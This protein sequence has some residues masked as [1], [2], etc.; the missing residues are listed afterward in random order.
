MKL[1]KKY[2]LLGP[3]MVGALC[4]LATSAN[5][6][7]VMHDQRAGAPYASVVSVPPGYTT[8]YIA[9]MASAVTNPSAPEGSPERI[10]DT[11]AQTTATLNIMKQVLAKHGLTFADV[12]QAR[13][14]LAGDPAK[15]GKMDYAGMNRA[16]KMEFGSATQPNAPARVTVQISALAEPGAL[17]EI[18]MTAAKKL[19]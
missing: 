3:A 16:W 1:L 7:E 15:G 5:A 8:Y 19:P 6:A 12:V 18:S 10:G 17:V 14:F 13:V 9:G 11:A 2:A 4:L